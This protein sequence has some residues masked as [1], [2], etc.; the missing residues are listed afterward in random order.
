[1]RRGKIGERER[2]KRNRFF[3]PPLPP[4]DIALH[5]RPQNIIHINLSHLIAPLSSPFTLVP[6]SNASP[7]SHLPCAPRRS[8]LILPVCTRRHYYSLHALCYEPIFVLASLSANTL[9]HLWN[10]TQLQWRV[11]VNAGVQY[12]IRATH[13]FSIGNLKHLTRTTLTPA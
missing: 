2:K 11:P 5:C 9:H 7:H 12:V 13:N 10:S 8:W 3:P 1:M 6:H 4:C